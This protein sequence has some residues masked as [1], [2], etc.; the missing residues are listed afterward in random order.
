MKKY[1][2]LSLIILLAVF[3]LVHQG[4]SKIKSYYSGDAVSFN[5]QLYIGTAN[6]NSLEV[7]KMEG[8]S[9]LPIAKIKPFDARFNRF[10]NF[11]D[12][13]L[14]VEDSHLFVY[15]ISDFSLY[16]YELVNGTNLTLIASQKNTYWEWYNRVDK[17]GDNL[18]TISSKSVKIWNRDLQVIDAFDLKDVT[19]PYNVRSNNNRFILNIQDNYLTVFDRE[20]RLQ[21]SNI[22]LNYKSNPGNHKSY[23]DAAGQIYVVDDYY[24][25][26][27]SLDGKLIASFKHLDYDAYDM[28]AS[29]YS[30][31]VYF[32]NGVG[33]VKLN[34]SDLSL[35]DYR[36]TNTLGGTRGWAMGLS[37]VNADGEKIVVFNNS[38][39]LVLDDDLNK[40]ANF[41]A[42]EI[43]DPSS[44][45]NLYLNLNR[46]FGSAG[47]SI[48]LNGGG[49]FPKE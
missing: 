41:S 34:S 15:A 22:A 47:A 28:T 2:F 1:I 26:K 6:T 46:N 13:K 9:L 33:V 42:T 49:F 11:Y 17:F 10:G 43:E 19:A 25:K 29:G 31:Y 23:Q 24:A 7:F 40:L 35:A 21:I 27:F 16:K 4:Q 3:A 48:E 14:I 36:F 32:S 39:I 44:T 8:S 45:E 18:V 30:D 20:N 12:V 38:N 5:N 37:V